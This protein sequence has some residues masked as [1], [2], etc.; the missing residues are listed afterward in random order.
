MTQQQPAMAIRPVTLGGRHIRLEPLSQQRH[1]AGLSEV[2]LDPEIW[3]WNPFHVNRTPEDMRHYIETALRQQAAGESLPFAT[4]EQASGRPVGS[5]RLV[6]I[7]RAN[8]NLEIGSTWI[9]P[10][11]QRTAVNTEAKYLMLRHA[12]ETLGC[13]RVEFKT[14]SLNERSRR[15]ILRLGAVEEGTLRNHMITTGG[16][17]RHS[18]Y[19][20][21]VEQEWPAVKARLE[22][23]LAA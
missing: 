4:I 5:T 11:W 8:R 15:A 2:G 22:E 16:R 17:I 21:I 10:P 1:H 6:K 3:R 19:Y 12:F 20:S 18:V 9:A 14:D 23:R 7:D 13:I